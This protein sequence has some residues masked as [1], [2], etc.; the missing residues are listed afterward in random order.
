MASF[1]PISKSPKLSL[2]L[3]LS[4]LFLLA[5]YIKTHLKAS[6]SS[7]LNHVAGS[8]ITNPSLYDDP[9]ADGCQGLH[10]LKDSQSKC[11]F[12]N[13]KHGCDPRGYINYLNI[14]YCI[15]G[16]H[17]FL[18]YTVLLLWLLLLF[19]LSGNTVSNYFCP[20]L[21]G[22]SQVL[23]L[24]PTIAGVTLLSLGNGASDVFASLVSFTS[25]GDARVGL[26]G[27]LGGAFFVSSA[28]VGIISVIVGSRQIVLD[29][30]SFIRDVL[31]LLF[32]LCAL[33]VIVLVGKINLWGA[34]CFVSI[35]VIYVSA[36]STVH[37]LRLKKPR[38]VHLLPTS[39]GCIPC[40]VHLGDTGI[41]LLY[42]V[43]E[44]DNKEIE[45]HSLED[46]KRVPKF[47]GMSSPT[48]IRYI[49]VLQYA[50]ELPIY[51]PRR[52]TIPLISEERW[53][54]PCAVTSVTLAP[55]LL[56]TIYNFQRRIFG[57]KSAEN[58]YMTAGLAGL[59][60]GSI[61]F[62]T[63][64]ASEPPKRCL[65]PWLAGGFVMSITWTYITAEEL[66]SLL[67]SLGTILG[68]SPSVLGVTV[69][70]WGNSVADLIANVTMAKEGGSDGVQIAISGCYAGPM[71]STLVGLGVSI[72]SAA[73]SAYPSAYVIPGD[74]STYETLGF[75]ISGLLWSLVMLP[76]KNMQLDWFLGGGLLAIYLC[77][78]SLRLA[79]ALGWLDFNHSHI[80]NTNGKNILIS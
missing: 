53:S 4:F 62:A 49:K 29:K 79:Q 44:D 72:V 38:M 60:F 40:H 5:F 68:T 6:D 78:L 39:T 2:F 8:S 17:P 26:S 42:S 32:S 66:V 45:K 57:S 74:S 58:I 64:K 63:T 30:H 13:S 59:V 37:Y 70:A 3:N 31:F 56:A 71:F 28:V 50:V 22:L 16:Q 52:L 14:F 47:S 9:K 10:E 54:K 80:F 21:E 12:V 23:N 55:L 20:S 65:F 24:S 75:L 46:Q 15:C 51:L 69:L 11:L 7:T 48:S 76:R 27:V 61:A 43:N 73:W 41:P 18:G 1:T 34:I 25:S 35:Y 33:L 19:Y 67:L 77:F 36:V